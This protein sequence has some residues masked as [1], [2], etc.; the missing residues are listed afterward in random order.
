MEDFKV[1]IKIERVLY[2]QNCPIVL[3]KGICIKLLNSGRKALLLQFRNIYEKQ[4]KSVTVAIDLYDKEGNC[5][6]QGAYR[7]QNLSVDPWTNFGGQQPI[8]IEQ[9][10]FKRTFS[11]PD[12]N[13]IF[14]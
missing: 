11:P 1:L 12:K 3:K 4:I 5:I 10:N 7:Y 9:N 2:Q 13:L 14:L 8:E 6:S